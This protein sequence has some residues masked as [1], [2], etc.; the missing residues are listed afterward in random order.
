MELKYTHG[1]C[2]ELIY[3]EHNEFRD[4]PLRNVLKCY[5]MG[6]DRVQKALIGKTEIIDSCHYLLNGVK[7]Q[8][9][10][11]LPGW[12]KCWFETFP[13]FLLQSKS[14]KTQ[15]VR[16]LPGHRWNAKST[17]LAWFSK[18]KCLL[19]RSLKPALGDNLWNMDLLKANGT[20]KP[21]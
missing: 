1:G 5:T 13:A 3:A 19:R 14:E 20:K 2:S 17:K 11:A 10:K 8:G 21:K 12:S 9:Q 6:P 4:F 16:K 18:I 15:A 7:W